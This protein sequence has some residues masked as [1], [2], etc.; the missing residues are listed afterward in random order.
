MTLEADPPIKW[1]YWL[2]AC[3]VSLGFWWLF[4]KILDWIL[5]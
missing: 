5:P 2:A 4:F 1:I 3:G